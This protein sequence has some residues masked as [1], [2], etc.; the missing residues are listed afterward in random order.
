MCNFD[1]KDAQDVLRTW[2]ANIEMNFKAMC[3]NIRELTLGVDIKCSFYFEYNVTK[4]MHTVATTVRQV[5]YLIAVG[6][7]FRV[8]GS[9]NMVESLYNVYQCHERYYTDCSIDRQ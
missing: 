8:C 4:P 5:H 2:N 1:T 9:I 3:G 7:H 6:G